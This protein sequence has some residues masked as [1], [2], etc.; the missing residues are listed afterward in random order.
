MRKNLFVFYEVS[1]F[2]IFRFRC[3]VLIRFH[4]EACFRLVNVEKIFLIQL[5]FLS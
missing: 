2:L 5:T 4:F 1:G 3:S